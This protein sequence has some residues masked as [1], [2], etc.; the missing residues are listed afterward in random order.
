MTISELQEKY[1]N[2][3]LYIYLMETDEATRD[4]I[5]NGIKEIYDKDI[6]G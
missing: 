3:T 1:P 2:K 6:N 5:L 4:F